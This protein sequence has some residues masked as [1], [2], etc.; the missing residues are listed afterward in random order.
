MKTM[1]IRNMNTGDIL[2]IEVVSQNQRGVYSTDK[3][4]FHWSCW[5]PVEGN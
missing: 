2:E 4:F 3:C 1:K 5:Q